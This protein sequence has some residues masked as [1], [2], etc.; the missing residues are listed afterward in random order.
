MASHEPVDDGVAPAVAADSARGVCVV[1]SLEE[2]ADKTGLNPAVLRTTV[3][4]YNRACETGRDEL[5]GK[6]PRYLRPIKK[7]RFYAA[8][9]VMTGFGSLGAIK[10]NY[11][12]EVLNKA[13]ELIPG[14]Y[15]AGVDANSIYAD[16]YVFLLPGNTFGVRP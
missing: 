11:K 15:A 3:D 14:L 12:I 2:L 10:I 5:F 16:T 1:G 7:P 4:E 9:L 6:N 13:Y 8:Q